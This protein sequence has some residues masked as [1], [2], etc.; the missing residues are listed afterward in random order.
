M[1]AAVFDPKDKSAV[2]SLRAVSTQAAL[3]DLRSRPEFFGLPSRVEIQVQGKEPSLQEKLQM[4]ISKRK[5]SPAERAEADA[6]LAE[7][8]P[9]ECEIDFLEEPK[10][11]AMEGEQVQ[12]EEQEEE[13]EQ[14]QEQEQEEEQEEGAG[15][16]GPPRGAGE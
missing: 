5:L 9:P 6:V 3:E 13:Q 10:N 12:E 14:E 15:A 4:E 16:G 2:D 7:C 11:D 1:A 8:W